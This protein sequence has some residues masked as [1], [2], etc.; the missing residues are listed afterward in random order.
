MNSRPLKCVALLVVFGVASSL[1]RAETPPWWNDGQ[2]ESAKSAD[3]PTEAQPKNRPVPAGD[4]TNGPILEE[5]TISRKPVQTVDDRARE[6]AVSTPATSTAPADSPVAAPPLEGEEAA[7]Y[8][9]QPGDLLQV[10]VWHEPDLTR[11]VRV[12]PD[13][14]I[15]YP[16][17]GEI[18]AEGTTVEALRSTLET[19]L[20]K[21]VTKA[22]VNVSVKDPDGNR[23]YI[24]GKVNRPGVYPFTKSI[25]VIQALTLAGGTSKFADIDDI[26]ILRRVQG[27]QQAY[28]FR[29]SDVERGRSL[30]QNIVLRSGD[31]VVVP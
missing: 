23:I 11:E 5:Y 15:T 7:R 16:L 6:Q 22:V 20:Q 19:K 10:S 27:K 18:E 25:D 2:N 26:K 4:P 8:V 31:V 29:F 24:V 21:Y 14:W 30:E 13:G 28:K 17:V 9:V 3:G 1:V 12:S